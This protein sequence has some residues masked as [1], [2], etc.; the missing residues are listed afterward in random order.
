L[1][2]V[3]AITTAASL[4][5]AAAAGAEIRRLE[6]VGA[7]ALDDKMRRSGI[8]KDKAIDAALWEGV[9]RVATEL[10]E[11]STATA[12]EDG[13]KPLASVLGRD[14]VSYT[15]SFRIVEDQG[16]RPTLFTENPDAATEYVVVVEV[17]VDVDRVR[18]SLVKAGLLQDT[19]AAVLTGIDLD[20]RGLTQY[21]GYQE[22]MAL[23]VSDRV[24]AASVDPREYERG[25][26]LVRVEAEWGAGE[27][28]ERLLAA[29]PIHLR[30][31]PLEVEDLTGASDVW[32][33]PVGRS[34]LVLAVHWS[35]PLAPAA[36][37]AAR[38]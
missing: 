15:K 26:A 34:L 11:E 8:P 36:R 13:A 12:P 27:L 3:V 24:G 18:A 23:L 7:V 5:V 32:G 37:G 14:M 21:A 29:A 38:N 2:V 16:E 33:R 6:V 28:L 4:L 22:L 35:E 9:S 25:R 19:A 1:G 10:L 30:I 31:T 20:V 17:Q